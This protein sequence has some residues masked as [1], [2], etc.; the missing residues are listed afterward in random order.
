M[1]AGRISY[2]CQYLPPEWIAAHGFEPRRLVP[3]SLRSA[4]SGGAAMLPLL[5]ERMGG[6][7][8]AAA[9]SAQ[10]Q[11]IE[12]CALIA[13]TLCDQ[14]RRAAEYLSAR[15][16]MPLFLFNLPKTWQSP[17]AA[18]L[19]SSE[20][21]RLGRFLEERGGTRP[22]ESRLIEVML[23]F[24][25][26]R[27]L[28]REQAAR[29]AAPAKRRLAIIGA[30]LAGD[31][32]WLFELL[33]AN[34]AAIALDATENGELAVPPPYDRRALRQNPLQ[35]LCAAY[36]GLP[37]PARR[38][39]HPFFAWIKEH[40]LSRGVQGLILTEHLWCDIWRAEAPRL[41]ALL[42]LPAI[43][44]DFSGVEGTRARSESRLQALLEVLG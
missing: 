21:L 42:P 44:I 26:E 35:E 37:H 40:L 22:N 27:A 2:D 5:S 8:Y 25:A 38:P 20:V 36:F 39:S 29:E 31:Q 16:A 12:F 43:E 34:A 19:Y 6:C 4:A 32:I 18:R 17:A 10:G 9:I 30:P 11:A 23:D 1:N 41:K 33:R 3:E 28:S 14:A 13:T 15:S 7:P 24:E